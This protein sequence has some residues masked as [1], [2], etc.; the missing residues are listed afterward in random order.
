MDTSSPVWAMRETAS[1]GR[2]KPVK[3]LTIFGTRPEAIKM[4][5]VVK[6]L[7]EDKH[8]SHFL[9]VTGQHREML[10]QV[11]ELFNLKADLDLNIMEE[12]QSL[13]Q[14][15]IKALRGLERT[16]EKIKPDL[17]LVHGDTTTT[18]VGALS[19]FYHRVKVAHVEAGLRSHDIQNPY[20]EE[21]NR[22]L[23]DALS[24]IYF[25]PT[26]Q[27]RKNL[28]RE[29]YPKEKIFVTGNTV[30]D[31]LLSLEPYL[32]NI[33]LPY[34][35]SPKRPFILVEVHRRE[36]WGDPLRE[37]SLGLKDVAQEFPHLDIAI[38]LHKNPIVRE[39][40]LPALEG[41]PNIHIFEPFSYLEFLSLMKKS[42]FIVS[43]SG[44]IQEEA[45]S[46]HRPVLVTRRVTER[47]EG[48]KAGVLEVVGVERE[49]VRN[50]CRTL[51]LNPDRIEQIGKTPNPFG[52][53][54]AASRIRDYLLH[55]FGF[56][57]E[58]PKSFKPKL[59]QT[60]KKGNWE[61]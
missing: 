6:A 22:R 34:P 1:L 14:I 53:G 45:P 61:K 10:D 56:I 42:L 37:I 59:R 40:V 35:L 7:I 27:A 2:N 41:T 5:P 15:T 32:D 43:D 21:M 8:F 49:K 19:A 60:Q 44:G 12:R 23:T 4:A 55:F 20:P 9:G 46:F 36:N 28:Q 57:E 47:P 25:A 33:P 52:D 51:V 38:S 29:G 24:E 3:I 58:V 31:A 16:I 11:L 13:T 48:V 30:V 39:N 18:F 17:V 50:S 54:R 26:P